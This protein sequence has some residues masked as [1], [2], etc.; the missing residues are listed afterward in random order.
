MTGWR[1][2]NRRTWRY[3]MA[4]YLV[5]LVVGQAGRSSSPE[6]KDTSSTQFLTVRSVDGTDR[7]ARPV[8]VAYRE[9]RGP[10]ERT[11]IPLLMLHGS[12]GT[13][14]DLAALARTLSRH[15]SVVVPDLPGFGFSS[16]NLPDY[17]IRAHAVYVRE[18]LQRLEIASVHVL[19]F[20]MGGGVAISLS[21]LDPARV[22]SL[23][24]LSATGVQEMELL[25]QY[26]INHA[27][28]GMQLG[29]LSLL[30]TA[31]LRPAVLDNL[32]PYARNFYDSDQ[33]PL[34]AAL[35][36][37]DAPALIVHGRSD[38]LVPIES[39]VEHARLI[40][41]SQL[42]V[43]EGSHFMLFEDSQQLAPIL[44]EFLARADRGGAAQRG[45]AEPERLAQAA[46]PFDPRIV[47][48]ARAVNAAVLGALIVLG[49]ALM[50]FPAAVIAGVIVAQGRAD[51]LLALVSCLIGTVVRSSRHRRA[52]DEVRDGAATTA[53]LVIGVVGGAILLRTSF[54]ANAP[55][56]TRALV[57]AGLVAAASWA[58]FVCTSQRRRLLLRSSWVRATRW[59]YWPPWVFY[60]PV[61]AWIAGLAAKY[62]S[63]T[64]FT[65]ANPGILAGG[66]VGES[67]F[68][69]LQGLRDAGDRVA[70]SVIIEG[71]LP[72]DEKRIRAA[73]FMRSHNLTLPVVLKP[74]E[75]QRG[76]GV[77]VARTDEALQTCLDRCPVDTI[78]QE[79]VPGV[80]FGVFYYRR[81]SETTGRILSLTEKRLPTVV[82]D[83]ASS[84]E[85]LILADPRTI[86]MARFHLAR[87]R[88][89]L[90]DVPASGEV[91]PLGDLGTHCRGALFQDGSQLQT[92]AIEQAFEEIA[93][94]FSGFHFGRF[95]VR[96]PSAD[97]FR[98][99]HFKVIELN[100][101]TS[102]ATH[103]YGPATR[104]LSAYRVLFEQW[105]LAFEIGA[106]NRTRG[107]EVTSVGTLARLLLRYRRTAKQHLNPALVPQP[108]P[109]D[110]LRCDDDRR[111]SV[112]QSRATPVHRPAPPV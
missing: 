77:V 55:A 100:G 52:R 92:P 79:Y 33:R 24:L 68:G 108:R 86:G 106:E 96:A 72:A 56:W 98:E 49:T 110:T 5:A 27:V 75:G 84:L 37:F 45:D 62:R 1:V 78:L 71:D 94:S 58:L 42:R 46:L 90:A 105:R 93:R 102:E 19:G 74:N 38:P 50:P 54:Y 39:A 12:P 81:P 34:R 25:G 7:P 6:S 10:A 85:R 51:I 36:S 30:N 89:R 40:P 16:T 20:S 17:S 112:A 14:E 29:S 64:V 91:V 80:E 48:R 8:R 97:A 44:D 76:S 103:I 101:V 31:L 11:G 18:M 61:V 2:R 41:Q 69:I 43:L 111:A 87:N 66:F 59:E 28:H 104:L 67:K 99:G 4:I 3:L 47:P 107:A 22:R 65:A 88:D 21:S 109:P 73:A 15:R 82:G 70:R 35:A 13:S 57:V 23:V 53:V 32:L 63:A 83:G 26:H 95:D 60:V 9:Y